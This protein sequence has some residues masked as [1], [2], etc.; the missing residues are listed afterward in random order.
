MPAACPLCAKYSAENCAL[1]QRSECP[2]LRKGTKRPRRENTPPEA[3]AEAKLDR[4]FGQIVQDRHE[5]EL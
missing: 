3:V 4:E 2:A 1:A 5:N